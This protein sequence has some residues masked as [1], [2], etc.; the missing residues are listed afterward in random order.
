MTDV[1]LIYCMQVFTNRNN[2]KI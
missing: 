1:P 2:H